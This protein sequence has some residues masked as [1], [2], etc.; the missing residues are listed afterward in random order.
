VAEKTTQDKA[1]LN[2]RVQQLL[3]Q[4]LGQHSNVSKRK[5]VQVSTVTFGIGTPAAVYSLGVEFNKSS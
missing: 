3:H 4:A 5:P 2:Q 1:V